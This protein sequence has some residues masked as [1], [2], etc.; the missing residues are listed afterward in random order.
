MN[1]VT[2]ADEAV[3][4][5]LPVYHPR[6]YWKNRT[7]ND[8]VTVHTVSKENQVSAISAATVFS[9]KGGFVQSVDGSRRLVIAGKIF[10]NETVQA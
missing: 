4:M 2:V 5:T 10:K 3:L 7:G 9:M 8:K 1:Q 6:R